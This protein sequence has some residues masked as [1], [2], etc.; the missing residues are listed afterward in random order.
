M[1]RETSIDDVKRRIRTINKTNETEPLGKDV[2]NP[3]PKPQPEDLDDEP[4]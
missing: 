4:Q 1:T 2:P 3:A